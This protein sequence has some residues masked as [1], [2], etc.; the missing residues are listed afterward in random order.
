M[1]VQSSVSYDLTLGQTSRVPTQD[2]TVVQVPPSIQPVVLSLVPHGVRQ[3]PAV[4]FNS[5]FIDGQQGRAP[6]QALLTSDIATISPGVWELELTLMSWFD[7]NGAAQTFNHTGVVI[8]Y[9]IG[10]PITVL[11]RRSSVGSFTD[12]NRMRVL[13]TSNAI[14]QI[15]NPG[16]LAAQNNE[17]IATIN[18]IRII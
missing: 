14:I 2:D 17:L 11:A 5:F 12:F 4:N 6:S 10:T 13:L 1:I 8:N 3:F 15:Q 18:A 16:T 7:Y 9:P